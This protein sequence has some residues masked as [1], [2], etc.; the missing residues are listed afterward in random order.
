MPNQMQTSE[1]KCPKCGEV[2]SA[3]FV[4][5]GL[6]PRCLL[7]M[8]LAEH[9]TTPKPAAANS[10]FEPPSPSEIASEFPELEIIELAGR[11]GMGAV[12]QAKQ[13]NLRRTVALK[14]L[15][16]EV[17][18]NP[19]FSIRFEREAQALA[20]LNHPNIVQVYHVGKTDRF[21]YFLMEY[22][23]GVNLRQAIGEGNLS[24]EEALTIVPQICSALQYA[25]NQGIVHRDIKP[26]N[27]LLDKDG[28]IK[29]TDFGLAK[30][31]NSNQEGFLTGTQQ[32][33]GTFHYMAPEQ[34]QETRNV[35][36]RADIYSLGVI[37]YEL[38]TGQ[39][40]IGRFSPPSQSSLADPRLDHVVMRTLENQPER[41]YQAASE[42]SSDI[43]NLDLNRTQHHHTPTPTSQPPISKP[44]APIKKFRE[45]AL[46]K[47]KVPAMLL[48]IT[49]A[50]G[51]IFSAG[52]LLQFLL[53][54]PKPYSSQQMPRTIFQ[55]T[56]GSGSVI[57]M[58][59]E[60]NTRFSFPA[61]LISFATIIHLPICLLMLIAGA[62]M[63]HLESHGFV[64]FVAILAILPINPILTLFSLVAGIWTL[65]V[66]NQETVQLAFAERKRIS[67][68]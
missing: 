24:S 47:V 60:P 19:D 27:I 35:D 15:P 8:G 10:R 38:L 5:G 44:A 7:V 39:L 52:L 26:E 46:Q 3:G 36:H 41:R 67:A 45:E 40:P 57:T 51:L 34:L 6:C 64:V 37:F 62:K 31:V 43:Q 53:L 65:V 63:K 9:G 25:H 32:V 17:A 28:K 42:I 20:L 58:T 66:V 48:Q 50:I 18:A 55:G 12:Y 29:I 2:P 33:M 23:E 13:K 54:V 56:A 61:L 59:A 68:N 11:G 30:M 22:V 1:K 16:P 4:N 14:I 21:Y 49:G